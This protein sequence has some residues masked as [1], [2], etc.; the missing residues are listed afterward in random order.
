MWVVNVLL[1]LFF[2]RSNADQQTLHFTSSS[3]IE[4]CKKPIFLH[5]MIQLTTLCTKATL[6]KE[7]RPVWSRLVSYYVAGER[8]DACVPM[9]DTVLHTCT[10]KCKCMVLSTFIYL[11]AHEGQ[12]H[13]KCHAN[14]KPGLFKRDDIVKGF[15]FYWYP[16]QGMGEA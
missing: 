7:P 11:C 1:L 10:R 4:E 14:P 8:L 3:W 16:N 9:R 6:S 2:F 15:S 12:K 5:T 13:G